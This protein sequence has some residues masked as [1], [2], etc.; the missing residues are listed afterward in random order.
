MIDLPIRQAGLIVSDQSNAILARNV[1][2][3]DGYKFA[4]HE[5]RVKRNVFDYTARDLAANRRAVEHPRHSHIVDVA[6]RASHF[7]TA[8][9]ARYRFADNV[10]RHAQPFMCYLALNLPSSCLVGKLPISE[11]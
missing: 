3:R 11:D 2:R 6:R 7:V 8:L 4:P 5:L 9:L 1:L 10:L